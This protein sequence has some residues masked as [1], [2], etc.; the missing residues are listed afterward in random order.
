MKKALL[1]SAAIIIG[2]SVAYADGGTPITFSTLVANVV[3]SI[4]A[5]NYAGVNIGSAVATVASGVQRSLVSAFADTVNVKNFGAVGDDVHDDTSAINAALTYARGLSSA[6][7][8]FPTG[9]YYISGPLNLEGLNQSGLLVGF[10]VDGYGA[11]IDAHNGTAPVFDALGSRALQIG[12]ITVSGTAKGAFQFGRVNNASSSA[13]DDTSLRDVTVSG[14]FS[15]AGIYVFACETSKFDKVTVWN[16]Y[17]N[18]G[19]SGGYSVI[20]DGINHFGISAAFSTV[21]EVAPADTVQSFNE[22]TCVSCDFRSNTGSVPVWLS[23]ANRMS[24]SK[25]SYFAGPV[26]GVGIKIYQPNAA[27]P[28]ATFLDLG[29]HFETNLS[30]CI[31]MTGP[32]G[33][34]FARM[35]GFSLYDNAPECTTSIFGIDSSSSLTSVSLRAADIRMNINYGG[36]TVFDNASAWSGYGSYAGP[37]TGDSPSAGWNLAAS[38]WTGMLTINGAP[39]WSGAISTSQSASMTGGGKLNGS[40]DSTSLVLTKG[41]TIGDGTSTSY[42]FANGA[43][44]TERMTRAEAAGVLRW[45]WGV[46]SDAVSSGDIGANYLIRRYHTNGTLIDTPFSINRNSG[47]TQLADGMQ[48]IGAFIAAGTTP[49]LGSGSSD[50]G[51][52]PAIAGADGAGRVTVGSSTN[53][54]KCTLTFSASWSHPPVCSVADETTATAV[55]PVVTTTTLAITGTLTAGDSLSYSCKGF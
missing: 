39:S 13:C 21:T 22:F 5:S 34:T 45:D 29:V 38:A 49:T 8:L 55:R 32:S 44:G 37:V 53:G 52:S 48:L 7:V 14:T 43:D 50:C 27:T 18:G 20:F 17:T 31:Q 23:S 4:T 33:K 41:L 24:F 15:L 28:A 1:A 11:V 3:A 40:F 25:D 35:E 2:G 26:G 30:T 12:G 19:A 6:R 10:S 16:S 46:S 51:T 47:Q 9:K 42:T 54:G 36:G